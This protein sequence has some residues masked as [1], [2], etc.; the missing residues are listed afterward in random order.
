MSQR[1]EAATMQQLCQGS[2]L[3]NPTLGLVEF[4]PILQFMNEEHFDLRKMFI[5]T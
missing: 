3:Q 1:A 4:R 2:Q 5:Q